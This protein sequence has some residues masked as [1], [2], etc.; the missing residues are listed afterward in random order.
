AA[1]F[2]QTSNGIS[3]PSSASTSFVQLSGL[4]PKLTCDPEIFE[5]VIFVIQLT[6]FTDH[7]VFRHTVGLHFCSFK[8]S[9]SDGFNTSPDAS[10]RERA[11]ADSTNATPRAPSDASGKPSSSFM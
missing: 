6:I 3:P 9:S 11:M 4:T 8:C 5:T 2:K 7:P 1:S 10:R